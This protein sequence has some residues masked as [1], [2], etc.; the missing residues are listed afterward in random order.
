MSWLEP[1]RRGPELG[2]LRRAGGA[3]GE[4]GLE[5]LPLVV[6]ERVDD[7]EADQRV[8]ILAGCS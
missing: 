2:H 4:V 8:Q 7:V 1:A 3:A 6:V 5:A